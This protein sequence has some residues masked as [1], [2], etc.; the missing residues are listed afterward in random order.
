MEVFGVIALVMVLMFAVAAAL[1]FRVMRR[2]KIFENKV[3]LSKELQEISKT[4]VV[5]RAACSVAH[6]LN[7]LFAGIRGAAECLE[8]A[9]GDDEKFNKYTDIILKSCDRASRLT[10]QMSVRPR[11]SSEISEAADAHEIIDE[12]LC[13]LEYGVG[14]KIKVEK[15]L[16]AEKYFIRANGDNVQ[17]L[18][19]NLGFNSKDAMPDGGMI[20]VTTQNVSLDKNNDSLL[21]VPAGEYLEISFADTG[22]GIA[23]SVKDRMFEPF[24]TTKETGK[25]T[26]LGLPAVYQV[27]SEAGGTLKVKTSPKGTTFCIYFPLVGKEVES[28]G[29]EQKAQVLKSKIM[30][31]DDEPFLLELM[32]DILTN[33][34]SEVITVSD[35][36]KAPETFEKNSDIEVVMMDVVMPNPD[37]VELY[38]KFRKINPKLKMVFLSGYSKDERVD[39]IVAKDKLTEFMAKP[40]KAADVVE[41]LAILLAKE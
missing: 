5:G 39:E 20:T 31:V 30:L 9:A 13:L 2:K 34:G 14:S 27:I 41:K 35:S 8:K 25:G 24:F 4:E 10:S 32:K 6:D 7:N 26:G 16:L 37:G 12:S 19:L 21:K 22:C 17:S 40:Y 36:Q 38:R 11:K 3:F 18:L 1:A 29:I 33:A 23:D 28:F 15:K